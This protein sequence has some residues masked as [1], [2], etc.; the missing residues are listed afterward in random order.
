MRT[1]LAHCQCL[2]DRIDAVVT[3]MTCITTLNSRI[4]IAVI[5]LVDAVAGYNT[6]AEAYDAVANFTIN[7]HHRMT[8]RFTLSTDTMAFTALMAHNIRTG[9]VRIWCSEGQRCMAVAAF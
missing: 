1:T 3:V 5:K 7:S 4:N 2:A 8:E 9:M 6:E